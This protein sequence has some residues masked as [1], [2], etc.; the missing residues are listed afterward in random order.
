MAADTG[1]QDETPSEFE[2]TV[3]FLEKM[4]AEC[5]NLLSLMNT[6]QAKLLAKSPSQP[7][8]RKGVNE[9][10]L[11]DMAAYFGAKQKVEDAQ[12]AIRNSL[13]T[14]QHK[15]KEWDVERFEKQT[16]CLQKV[17]EGGGGRVCSGRVIDLIKHNMIIY[18]LT[19]SRRGGVPPLALFLGIPCF[20]LWF[21]LTVIHGIGRAALP[22]FIVNAKQKG[23][24]P[25]P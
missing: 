18:Y 20:P 17:G 21:E 15:K 16:E 6:K 11:K 13:L 3:V 2:D 14:P 23:L 1:V 9:E 24:I 25:R 4:R 12:Q 7:Y 22:C 10:Y 5:P 8:D 19:Q